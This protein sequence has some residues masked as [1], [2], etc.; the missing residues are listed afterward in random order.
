MNEVIVLDRNKLF[1]IS[2]VNKIFET[3]VATLFRCESHSIVISEHFT[4]GVKHLYKNKI[5][6]SAG[7]DV[8][9]IVFDSV[10]G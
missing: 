7:R 5:V 6:V 4:Q 8:V 9:T 1:R 2:H 10:C 3:D